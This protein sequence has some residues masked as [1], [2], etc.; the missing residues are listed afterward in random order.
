MA[1]AA[2][3][4]LELPYNCDTAVVKNRF[5]KL[6]GDQSV[7]AIAAVTD[8]ALGVARVDVSAAEIL[9]PSAKGTDVQVLGVAW[10]E[11]AA[12][13]TRGNFVGPSINGRAQTCVAT[14]FPAGIALK[15]A[16]NAGDWILVLLLPGARGTAQGTA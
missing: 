1:G 12:A 16:A 10:V 8:I 6:T 9:A 7:S 13:I 4:I 5:V 3:G 11:A 15:A 2:T 14:Q